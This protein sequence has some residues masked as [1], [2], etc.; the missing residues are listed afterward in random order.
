LWEGESIVQ[1]AGL[2]FIVFAGFIL[3]ALAP[4]AVRALKHRAGWVV[5]L[6][7]SAIFLLLLAFTPGVLAGKP[8]QAMLPWAPSLDLNLS[9]RLDGLGL[10][11]ALLISGIGTLV[12]IYTGGYM[13]GR[14]DTPSFYIYLLWFM[15]SMLGVVLSDNL[16]AVFVF[17]ELTSI[18]SYLLIGFDHDKQSSRDGALKALLITGTGGLAMLAGFILLGQIAGTFE[19]SKIA[20]PAAAD[21]ALITVALSL[22]LVGAFTKSAQWPFHIWLPD[23]MQA[24]TPVSA[25]LHSATM[26]KAGVYLLARLSPIFSAE[27]FWYYVVPTVGGITMLTGGLLALKQTDMKAI[28]AYTTIGWL[29][30][31]VML[32]GWGFHHA[33]EAAMLGILAHALYKGALFL[34]AGGIDHE[35]GT[36]DIRKL[37]NLNKVMPV[38]AVLMGIAAFSMAGIPLFLGF[39]SKELLLDATLHSGYPLALAWLAP[40]SVLVAS[41]INVAIGLRLFV[42][43]F[44][45][46][47]PEP[48][49]ML[50]DENLG[51]HAS[52]PIHDPPFGMLLGPMVLGAAT[53]LFG[54]FPG[55]INGLVSASAGVSLGEVIDVKL[56]LWH[57]INTPLTLSLT[58]LGLGVA[59][60]LVYSPSVKIMSALLRPALDRFYEWTLQFLMDGSKA[61][62]AFLQNG[63]LRYYVMVI[64]LSSTLLVGYALLGPAGGIPIPQV[65]APNLAELLLSTSL[66]ITALMVTQAR[67]RLAAIAGLGVIGALVSLF[68]VLFSAPDLALT[69]FIIETLMVI[70][71]LL[72]FHFLPRF[73][74]EFTSRSGRLRDL[75][76]STLVGLTATG[77]VLFSTANHFT[78]PGIAEYFV[79][80][81]YKLAH[82]TNIVNVILVDFRGFDTLGEIT[83][84]VVAAT[85]IYAMLKS[86]NTGGSGRERS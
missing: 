79:E 32:L 15:A 62:T 66:I 27:P 6:L 82:G 1:G 84:L 75:G 72:V 86:R 70:V 36:R 10:L 31:L 64:L 69:Q 18:T 85:G 19:I 12:V 73:F 29:G 37:G 55:L 24:P 38:S 48:G 5:S 13:K 21:P 8:V 56:A 83:V 16:L 30:T 41:L 52:H 67:G 9:L 53:L 40:G 22:I 3:A 39:V 42:G 43:V 57:G 17:W 26:V 61:V 34:L 35:T 14:E 54:M 7:P 59:L 25:Y 20:L 74:D 44:F 76:I 65:A 11:F 33:V 46:K 77:L 78:G 23:A 4:L 49:T 63:T 51:G 45:R 50:L 68:F 28:L 58:A 80:N 60:Y 81:S 2:S 47:A 71:F